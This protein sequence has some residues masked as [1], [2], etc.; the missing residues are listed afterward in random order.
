MG[1][2]LLFVFM[3]VSIFSYYGALRFLLLSEA[4]LSNASLEE[5][6]TSGKVC[7]QIRC[8]LLD[9][10][11]EPVLVQVVA[12][13]REGPGAGVYFKCLDFESAVRFNRW[14][15]PQYISWEVDSI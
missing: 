1:G 9:L 3:G 15:Y 13:T 10:A 7:R 12:S 2:W 6:S 14:S 4:S 5:C 8:R 11:L